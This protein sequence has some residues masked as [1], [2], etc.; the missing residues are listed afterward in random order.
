MGQALQDG[1]SL[2]TPN[3]QSNQMDTEMKK[4]ML[5]GMCP[6]VGMSRCFEANPTECKG[7]LDEGIV[8]LT[9]SSS[10]RLESS[11]T[12][13]PSSSTSAIGKEINELDAECKK[14]GVST[15]V[16]ETTEKVVTVVTLKGVD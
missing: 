1:M 9:P 8:K 15:S 10:R 5:E 11:S 14:S 12:P 2:E 3:A 13:T 16:A 7:M 6:M 4:S